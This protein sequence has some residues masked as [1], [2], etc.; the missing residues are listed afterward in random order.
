MGIG[1]G[2][3]YSFEGFFIDTSLNKAVGPNK[4]YAKD[5]MKFLI[6]FGYSGSTKG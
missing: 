1:T 5:S 2:I 6:S 3:R 4:E